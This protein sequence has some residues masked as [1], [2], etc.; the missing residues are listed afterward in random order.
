MFNTAY[1]NSVSELKRFRK[2]SK[3]RLKLNYQ[4]NRRQ[5]VY[6]G[7]NGMGNKFASDILSMNSQSELHN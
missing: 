4:E 7:Y 5:Y 1:L 3:R 2:K 6:I